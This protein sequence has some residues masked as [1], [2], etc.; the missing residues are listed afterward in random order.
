MNAEHAKPFPPLAVLNFHALRMTRQYGPDNEMTNLRDQV[1]ALVEAAA[2]LLKSQ[3]GP[4]ER[5]NAYIS[6]RG[7]QNLNA[8][9]AKTRAAL[10]PFGGAA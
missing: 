8:A 7:A 4:W 1:T 9:M 6:A 2:E 3:G 5:G 10:A